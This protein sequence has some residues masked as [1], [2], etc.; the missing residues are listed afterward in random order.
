MNPSTAVFDDDAVQVVETPSQPDAGKKR[1]SKKKPSTT[2]NSPE[3][4]ST[5]TLE[6]KEMRLFDELRE[7]RL[8]EARRRRIPAFRILRDRVLASISR[9]RPSDEEELLE[10]SGIGPAI[11]KKYGRAILKVVQQHGT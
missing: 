9:A 3:T 2:P 4:S 6:P 11:A 1:R 7:W 8:G 5:T 10:I